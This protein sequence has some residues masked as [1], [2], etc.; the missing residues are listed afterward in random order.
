M[1]FS[2][3]LPFISDYIEEISNSIYIHSK[4]SRYLSN[5]EKKWLSFCLMAIIVTN[6]ICWTRFEQ[7]S[8]GK[9]SFRALSWMFRK[10]QIPWEILLETSTRVILRKYNITQG[11]LIIDDTDKKRSKITK[12]IAF[13]HKLPDKSTGGFINGQS[14]VFLI[15]VSSEITIPVG[16]E[17]YQPDRK[18]NDWYKQNKRLKKGGV[19]LK[20][21][22]KRPDR[23]PKFPTKSS[24]AITLLKRFKEK[25]P[26]ITVKS[27]LADALYGSLRFMD[28]ASELFGK[29][30]ISQLRLNQ[31]VKLQNKKISVEE[32]FRRYPPVK[33]TLKVRGGKDLT[34]WI[35]SARLYV[36]SH[37]KKRFIVAI[38]YEQDGDY[39]YLLASDLS[40]RTQDIANTYTLRWLI[41]VFFEDWKAHEGWGNLTKQQGEEGSYRSLILSLLTDHSILSH[42]EQLAQI[43]HQQP[44]F[45]VGSLINQTKARALLLLIQ[46]YFNFDESE[47]KYADFSKVLMSFFTLKQSEKHMIGRNLGR[48]EPTPSLRSRIAS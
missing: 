38:K 16:F 21:R 18:F 43:K 35:N 39:K 27:V 2:R 33:K 6:S 17:F 25:H 7:S 24:I 34:V 29:Q 40:W 23:D 14:I 48:M 12:K 8:L 30:I 37:K 13:A 9:Y 3:P 28:S 10:S 22:P 45:T 1:I 31:I 4:R 32:Y 11:T 26:T 15:L 47:Q 5:I 19:S 42:P 20:D 41:E 36:H 44:A 46:D